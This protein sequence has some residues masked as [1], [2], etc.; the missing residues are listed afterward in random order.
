MEQVARRTAERKGVEVDEARLAKQ[1]AG[2]AA[3]FDNQSDAFFTSGRMLDMGMIDPRDS[4]MV[5]GFC[6]ATCMEARR[7]DLNPNA[8][9]VGR[10]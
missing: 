6:L 10:A 7:R 2:I 8:F 9:G 1:S 3:H 4:R 5:I